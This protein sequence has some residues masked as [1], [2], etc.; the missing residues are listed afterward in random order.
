MDESRVDPYDGLWIA[1]CPPDLVKPMICYTLL[2]KL[3]ILSVY[4]HINS[5]TVHTLSAL[6]HL[7]QRMIGTSCISAS[8]FGSAWTAE[9]L[10][11]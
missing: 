9:Q 3:P 8:H 10:E 1:P 2:P 11:H 5:A 4:H 7:E 6:C